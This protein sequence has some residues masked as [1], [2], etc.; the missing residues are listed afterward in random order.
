MVPALLDLAMAPSYASFP[1]VGPRAQIFVATLLPR[2]KTKIG[3]V[4]VFQRCLTRPPKIPPLQKNVRLDPPVLWRDVRAFPWRLSMYGALLRHIGQ[5]LPRKRGEDP[6]SVTLHYSQHS[7]CRDAWK[8]I[9]RVKSN[10]KFL[11]VV[12]DRKL[13]YKN[14]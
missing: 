2:K 8:V 4:G 1:V 6:P 5:L 3:V 13:T 14:T 11:G 9:E 10:A 7:S 12:P